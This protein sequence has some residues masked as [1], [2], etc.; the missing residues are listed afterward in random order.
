MKLSPFVLGNYG[1]DLLSRQSEKDKIIHA[2]SHTVTG[3][4]PGPYRPKIKQ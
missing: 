4:A 1:Y 2:G 3:I